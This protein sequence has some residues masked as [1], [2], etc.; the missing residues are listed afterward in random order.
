[1][2]ANTSLWLHSCKM[3]VPR[4]PTNN[5]AFPTLYNQKALHSMPTQQCNCCPH[6]HYG[7]WSTTTSTAYTMSISQQIFYLQGGISGNS[8]FCHDSNAET[9]VSSL[10]NEHWKK[11]DLIMIWLW[12]EGHSTTSLA[13]DLFI[14][15][16][17]GA[18]NIYFDHGQTDTSSTEIMF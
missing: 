17:D 12:L 15:F 2:P 6:I 13:I 11:W 18:L 1:M 16:F 5:N 7:T 3:L 9:Y 4:L 14:G 10:T 8:S